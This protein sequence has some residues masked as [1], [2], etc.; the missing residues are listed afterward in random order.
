MASGMT[1]SPRRSA[2]NEIMIN[3]E[4]GP[5]CYPG[6]VFM[7]RVYIYIQWRRSFSDTSGVFY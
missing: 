2:G 3:A 7:V 4:N 1:L 6:G 5:V